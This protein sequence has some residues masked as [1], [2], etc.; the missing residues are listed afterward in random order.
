MYPF[1]FL[2]TPLCT[3][4]LTLKT[5]ESYSRRLKMKTAQ[6]FIIIDSI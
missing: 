3:S 5:N 2:N 4:T 6:L 1:R